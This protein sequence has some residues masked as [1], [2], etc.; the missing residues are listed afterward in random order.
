MKSKINSLQGFRGILCLHVFLFHVLGLIGM[1]SC[2]S[3]YFMEAGGLGVKGF[4]LISGCL[5]IINNSENNKSYP[6]VIEKCKSF[7]K[8]YYPLH[9]AFLIIMAPFTVQ[10]VVD[11]S[12][13]LGKMLSFLLL[14]ATLLHAQI[15]VEGCALSFN[16]V[17][18]YLSTALFLVI[19][20]I[21]FQGWV[22][23]F[24]KKKCVVS[25]CL[26][27]AVEVV[28]SCLVW[29]LPIKES[30]KGWLLY[31][32]F[33]SR[34]SD[35]ILGMIIGRLSLI[36][37]SRRNDKADALITLLSVILVII[38]M[39]NT[40]R[41]PQSL[42]YSAMFSIPLSLFLY[43]ILNSNNVAAKAISNIIFTKIGDLSFYIYISHLA[44]SKYFYKL[45]SHVGSLNWIT[46]NTILFV[47]LCFVI[48]IAV[49]FFLYGVEKQR[50]D[51][52]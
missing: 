26:V 7:L 38:I 28:Y 35:L 18:W 10:M 49:S 51:K 52:K 37:F 6:S 29:T 24:S 17:S 43:S 19:M 44:V 46:Q 20:S 42:T 45:T 13:S 27:L 31:T 21:M 30:M 39:T 9:I 2:A 41:I 8:K 14:N 1:R 23:R 47:G 4:F 15:P 32:P 40:N 16:D 34:I 33:W 48:T 25:F 12:L 3:G 50:R 22:A 11:G 36:N 5:A